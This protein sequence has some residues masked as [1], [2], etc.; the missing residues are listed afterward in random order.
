MIQIHYFSHY[1][2]EAKLGTS[3]FLAVQWPGQVN[4]T[5][6]LFTEKSSGDENKARLPMN[7]GHHQEDWPEKKEHLATKRS[8]LATDYRQLQPTS[9]PTYIRHQLEKS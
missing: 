6:L 1:A 3:V 7:A 8:R 2:H 9:P 5:V 4:R